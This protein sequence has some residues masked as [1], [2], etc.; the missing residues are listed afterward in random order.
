ML[1][2]YKPKRCPQLSWVLHL[3]R[4]RCGYLAVCEGNEE[5]NLGGKILIRS[6]NK[7]TSHV[8]FD[9]LHVAVSLLSM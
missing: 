2:V 7:S 6:I 3:I 9:S 1:Q 8:G 5:T 4:Y